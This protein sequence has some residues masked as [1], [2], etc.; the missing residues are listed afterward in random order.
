MLSVSVVTLIFG[1][2]L[3]ESRAFACVCIYTPCVLFGDI[4]WK[5]AL[6]LS[7]TV[8]SSLSYPNVKRRQHIWSLRSLV[9]TS[10]T[11]SGG[12]ALYVQECLTKGLPIED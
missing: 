7:L 10:H 1:F 11:V 6:L 12:K 2:H 8:I 4:I 9:D 5:E 3:C